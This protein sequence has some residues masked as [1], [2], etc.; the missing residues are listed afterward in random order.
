[1]NRTLSKTMMWAAIF[2]ILATGLIHFINMSDAYHDMAYKGILFALNGVGALVSAVGIYRG[3]RSWGWMLGIA[4]AGGALLG[5]IA[6][7]TIG[8][9]GL[10]AEPDAWL[11][12]MGVASMLAEAGFLMI[13]FQ[14]L[15]APRALPQA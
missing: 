5:Y 9:P 12:P 3:A 4:V 2:C 8:L 1:M 15:R 11:E 6:S 13:A 10:P 7:R 14:A